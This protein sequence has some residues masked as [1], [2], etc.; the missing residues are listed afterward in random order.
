[1]KAWLG[2]FFTAQLE[3]IW[4]NNCEFLHCLSQQSGFLFKPSFYYYFFFFNYYSWFHFISCCK[5]VLYQDICTFIKN[6][7]F[8]K[9][10]AAFKF[11]VM[12]R[13]VSALFP[14]LFSV[15]F[16][17]KSVTSIINKS[18]WRQFLCACVPHLI[19]HLENNSFLT[20]LACF[21]L[22]SGIVHTQRAHLMWCMHS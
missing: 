7:I 19:S 4:D 10:Q 15:P 21:P 12:L 11:L 20:A 16:R 1:M 13:S 22:S 14:L 8:K 3:G 9:E 17:C 2:Q 5:Q 18:L 6:N